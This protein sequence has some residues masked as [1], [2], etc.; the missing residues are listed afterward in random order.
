MKTLI[1]SSLNKIFKDEK[2]NF[3]EFAA[4]SILNNE[5]FSFQVAFCPETKEET[6]FFINVSSPLKKNLSL[7]IVKNMPSER[8]GNEDSD[9]FHYDLTRKEFPDL[10]VP[11]TEGEKLTFKKGE[12]NS[13][14]VEYTPT[15]ALKGK[16]KIAL[17]LEG[18]SFKKEC[19][20]NLNIINT[21][22]PEQKLLY[23][24]WF[25]NDCLLTYYDIDV[26]S[27]E[28][29]C[30]LRAY[31]K[32]AVHHGMNMILTPVFTPPLDTEVGG[33]RPTVQL[34]KVTK[35][36]EKYSFD[37]ENFEKYVKLCLECG[38]K[39]FEISHFFTQWGAKHAPKIIATVDG[40]EKKIFGWETEAKGD[41]YSSFLK[42]FAKAFDKE[43]KALGIK[44]KC[45]LHVS[46]EPSTE[47]LEDYRAAAK[48]LHSSFKGFNSI[49]ALSDID[50]FK[51]GLIKTPIPAEDE[52]DIFKKEVKDFWTYHCCVQVHKFLPNRMFSQPSQR[53]RVLG[54]L[55]YKY[56]AKGFLQW[57]HNF[58]YSQY[59]KHPIDPFKVTAAGGAFPSGDSFVVY[60]GEDRKPLNS[61]RH[62]VFL[63]A[64]QD[65]RALTLLES[66]KGRD[67]VMKLIE[68][69]LDTPLSFTSYPHQYT[70]LLAL[71]ERVNEELNNA[72]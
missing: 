29:W 70:W 43:V 26:F 65:M 52:A 20:F 4:Y 42:S 31:V 1:L 7:Y 60:P 30:V 41:E 35:T 68:K 11:V 3:S 55:L 27:E 17:T 53:N 24:N 12:Y 8:T 45:W 57:G 18:K 69:D 48:I 64:M 14:W 46:D 21:A 56:E 58:W 34:V 2:P 40:T 10:L 23:T 61:L 51:N 54:V 37:F 72:L 9:S 22:L 13:I 15:K 44:D 66:I 62:K 59:S 25:H 38:I 71:R 67:F 6:E 16:K 47:Q 28:Y 49:D 5:C 36:G 32:N 39:A 33:E 50:F 19:I 63:D